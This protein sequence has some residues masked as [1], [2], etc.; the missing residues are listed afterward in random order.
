MEVCVRVCQCMCCHNDISTSLRFEMRQ[1]LITTGG[2]VE[3]KKEK[4]RTT[5]QT[6]QDNAAKYYCNLRVIAII[7][8]IARVFSCLSASG[9]VTIRGRSLQRSG[10]GRHGWEAGALTVS[11]THFRFFIACVQ[12]A[13]TKKK[14]VQGPLI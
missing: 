11:K 10:V 9:N 4:K 8:Y 13:I 12:G 7:S 3:K 6:T 14:N 5:D 2:A 1:G